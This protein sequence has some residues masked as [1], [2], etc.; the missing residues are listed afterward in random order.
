MI[1]R[2]FQ[3]RKE[4][5]AVPKKTIREKGYKKVQKQGPMLQPELSILVSLGCHNQTT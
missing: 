5:E 3:P 2:N 4:A 1:S